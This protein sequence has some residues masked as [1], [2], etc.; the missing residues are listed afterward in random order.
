MISRFVI[1]CLY[2]DFNFSLRLQ[3][4]DT[5]VCMLE[6]TNFMRQVKRVLG[7][8]LK[9]AEF[10][11]LNLKNPFQAWRLF[12]KLLCEA[13]QYLLEALETLNARQ[14]SVHISAYFLRI[15]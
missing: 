14:G 3:L 1:Y 2:K 12:R 6:R 8:I 9:Q 15:D 4:G 11:H 10:V 13:S 5:D 7:L